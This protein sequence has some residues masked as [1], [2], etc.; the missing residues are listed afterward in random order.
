[1]NRTAEI[2]RKTK[3]TNIN[4]K[5][6]LDSKEPIE[7]KTGLGFFDHMLEQ[8]AY[9]SKASLCI[10]CQG[11]LH[12]DE[13][14]TIEDVGL[15]L[16]EAYKTAIGD[17]I[18]LERYGFLLPMD[19]ALAQVALDFSGRPY[20]VFKAEFKREMIGD[21]PTEMFKHFFKSFCDTS[22]LTLNIQCEGDNEHHKIE[23]IFKAFGKSLGQACKVNKDDLSIPSS[24]GIL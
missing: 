13:H 24:K 8:I 4:I 21:M 15:A 16:G 6:D 10:S 11:D 5:L 9:H 2:N 22:G 18:G 19:E 17:K 20:L 12:I 1:M 14:H 3:E 23:S 7:I